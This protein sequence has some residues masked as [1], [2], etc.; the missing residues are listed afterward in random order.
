M[1]GSYRLLFRVAYSVAKCRGKMPARAAGA[2]SPMGRRLCPSPC[3]PAI[4]LA[5]EPPYAAS[6]GL[7]VL[8]EARSP[9]NSGH[10]DWNPD[11][12]TGYEECGRRTRFNSTYLQ[13][14][15]G[16]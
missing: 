6:F 9:R 16:L 5:G 10:R 12:L 4:S 2:G 3:L 1:T 15:I 14:T 7:R 11:P 8:R 13:V